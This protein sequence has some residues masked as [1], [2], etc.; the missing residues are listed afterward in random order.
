MLQAFRTGKPAV[1]QSVQTDKWGSFISAF[2]PVRDPYGNVALIAGV[3]YTADQYAAEFAGV[4][5]ATLLGILVALVGS[6]LFGT[7]VFV[8]QQQ[9]ETSVGRLKAASKTLESQAQEREFYISQLMDMKQFAQTTID[10]LSYQVAVLDECGKIITVNKT[11][12]AFA[13]ANGGIEAAC[14]IGANYLAVCDEAAGDWN[15]EAPDV[16][17]GIRAVMDG[18]LDVFTLEYPCH[19]PWELRWFALR[20]T[21]FPGDGPVRVVVA[22]EDIS[23]RKRAEIDLALANADLEVRVQERT[24]S[25]EQAH[26]EAQH[27]LDLVDATVDGVFIFDQDFRLTYV[28]QGAIEQVGYTREELHLMSILDIKPEY[29]RES[30]QQLLTPLTSRQRDKTSIE[31]VHRHHDGRNIPV[32]VNLR[33]IENTGEAGQYVSVARDITEREAARELLVAAKEEAEHANQAKSE[34]LSR[35][36]HEL[37]TP[38]NAVLGFAQLLE[39]QSD[40]P[41]T[42]QSAES[43][44]RGGKHLLDLVNEVLDMAKIEVGKLSVALNVV[45]I[46]EIVASSIEL[47]RPMADGKGIEILVDHDSMRGIRV[48]ADRQ[49]LAQV[50]MNLLSNAIKYN[51]HDGRVVVRCVTQE[52]AWCRIEFS[53]TGPGIDSEN[54]NRLFVPFERLGDGQAEGTG[55]GLVVSKGLMELMGGNLLLANTSKLGSTFA[56]DLRTSQE[57][58]G[59]VGDKI[60]HQNTHVWFDGREL[61]IVYVEDNL[62]NILLIERAFA[63]HPS[64]ELAFA[65]DVANGLKLIRQVVPDLVLLDL[66]LPDGTGSDV[67]AG[68]LQDPNTDDI[69]V[70]ILSADVSPSQIEALTR[71]G[72]KAYLTKPIEVTDLFEL[73]ETLIPV[74]GGSNVREAAR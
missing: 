66:H 56:I 72:A 7:G 45:D 67:L 28:N 64:V 4:D 52:E 68:M 65:K 21:R 48:E 70:V 46:N 27:A 11:W 12:N 1:S 6:V 10:A 71:Q 41:N 51:R 44:I 61:K 74:N 5:R 38:L 50:V 42:I 30:F 9:R 34:F 18:E 23:Q 58:A 2:A 33:Y 63:G 55:L 57:A 62:D 39:I 47:L 16:A 22:H 19:S 14:G 59:L 26:W 53:D 24:M 36:S 35:M 37:R 31:T 49:R 25:L 73:I 8:V 17:R 60:I 13:E 43:I 32:E 15:A 29:N 20:V 40:D 69:P 3:D 54:L